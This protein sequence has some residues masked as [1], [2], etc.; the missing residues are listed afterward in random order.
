MAWP[1]KGKKYFSFVELKFVQD[2]FVIKSLLFRQP[3]Y[4]HLRNAIFITLTKFE[5]FVAFHWSH[6]LSL[7]SVLAK[8]LKL[9]T[10]ICF[11]DEAV[12]DGYLWWRLREKVSS[13]HNEENWLK[14]TRWGKFK[15]NLQSILL[16]KADN[17]KWNYTH[18]WK[19][20]QNYTLCVKGS[21]MRWS[22]RWECEW[23][24][25]CEQRHSICMDGSKE[26]W[27]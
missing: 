7:F 2:C 14:L 15:G 16:L 9:F 18:L 21:D 5:I 13:R 8:D 19:V 12:F 11:Y 24:I 3:I 23:P 17:L 1:H 25:H 10:V 20:R 22:E 26:C 6:S 27:I 4:R